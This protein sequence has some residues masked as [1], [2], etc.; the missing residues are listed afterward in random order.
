MML[1]LFFSSIMDTKLQVIDLS[2]FLP[3]H[4]TS[5]QQKIV[6]IGT[7]T[8]FN[9]TFSNRVRMSAPMQTCG[10]VQDFTSVHAHTECP[11]TVDDTSESCFPLLQ[12]C[13]EITTK[14]R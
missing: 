13:V 3:S 11:Q 7:K 9:I 4:I 5:P 12:S 10:D 2:L 1:L 8:D 14:V 6:M